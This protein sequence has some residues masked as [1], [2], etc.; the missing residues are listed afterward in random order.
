MDD[1]TAG[2]G[3]TDGAPEPAPIAERS[4]WTPVPTQPNA[5]PP[6][7]PEPAP[8]PVAWE[9]PPNADGIAVPGA[10]GL[11]YAGTVPRL[12]AYLVD[13]LVVLV[14]AVVLSIVV[15]LVVTV[16]AVSLDLRGGSN[17]IATAVGGTGFIVL[18]LVYFVLL[19]TGRRRATFGMRLLRLQIG[20]ASD[21]RTLTGEQ[22][23]KRWIGYGQWLAVLAI[24][25]AL[26]SAANLV[27]LLWLVVLLI[28]VAVDA[29]HQGL[30]D[31]FAGSA[32]VQTRGS[33]N[34]LVVGCLILVGFFVFIAFV[35]IVAL[36]FLGTAVSTTRSP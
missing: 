10:P 34:T 20:N 22:A 19:W 26:A 8:A 4:T 35:S 2:P 12:L 21:G 3:P 30:H 18:D 15:G 29:T 27:G 6:A 33:S 13:G 17:A 16:V 23:V 1:P 36:I 5:A 24:A 28:S 25:P 32:I 9:A 31:K 7:A 11:I 14:I